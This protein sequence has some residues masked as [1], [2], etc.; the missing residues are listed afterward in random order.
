MSYTITYKAVKEEECTLYLSYEDNV[1]SLD[2]AVRFAEEF[3]NDE[4]A[5]GYR[6]E[7][8][9]ADKFIILDVSEDKDE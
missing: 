6:M 2:E 1:N 8:N 7:G 9:I 4:M 5:I 3:K